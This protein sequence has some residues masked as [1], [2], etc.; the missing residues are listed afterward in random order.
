MWGGTPWWSSKTSPSNPSVVGSIPGQGASTPHASQLENQN[1]NNIVKKF[2]KDL[3]YSSKKCMWIFRLK[4]RTMAGGGGV[5]MEEGI[6][7]EF[8]VDIYTLLY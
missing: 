6:V 2:N 7:R 4:E 3:K 8:R 1:I 5:R